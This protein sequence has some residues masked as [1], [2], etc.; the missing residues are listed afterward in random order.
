MHKLSIRGSTF[1]SHGEAVEV[2][3]VNAAKVSRAY[4][5]NAFDEVS[6]AEKA[7]QDEFQKAAP[8][9]FKFINQVKKDLGVSPDIDPEDL[10]R[11]KVLETKCSFSR[12]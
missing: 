12:C 6:Y 9:I 5:V 3:I 10:A 2:V 11:I 7:V 8:E 4:F 1:A